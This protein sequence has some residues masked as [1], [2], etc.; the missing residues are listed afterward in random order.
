M[1]FVSAI[2]R[3]QQRLAS[4]VLV[5]KSHSRWPLPP[6]LSEPKDSL[7]I[8]VLDSSF[9]PPTLAHRALL[10]ASNPFSPT[11]NYDANLLLLSVRNADKSLKPGDASLSQRLEMMIL[12]TQDMPRNDNVAVAIIDQPTFFGKSSSLL[13]FLHSHVSSISFNPV[14]HNISFQLM[15]LVGFDTLERILSHR[16]YSSE[17]EMYRS[18]H[19]FLSED[20]DDSRLVCARRPGLTPIG[21]ESERYTLMVAKEFSDRQRLAFIDLA[22]TV[23]SFSSSYIRY[24]IA[25]SGATWKDVTTPQIARYVLNHSLYS[26]ES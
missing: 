4:V 12:L 8:N 17:P 11:H 6:N 5:Y 18:L 10:S 13:Q 3:V 7:Q 21:S 19:T 24:E 15:F 1:S 26:V 9:N 23:K 25:K 16:Y 22:D 14:N 20:G 2:E